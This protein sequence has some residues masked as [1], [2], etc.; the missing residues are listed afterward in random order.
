MKKKKKKK[1]LIPDIKK[2]RGPLS[3]ETRKKI[4]DAFRARRAKKQDAGEVKEQ[5]S[6]ET[7]LSD[8]ELLEK[9]KEIKRLKIFK[10]QKIKEYQTSHGSEYFK[11]FDYQE[12]FLD[13]IVGGKKVVLFQG[14]NQTG[15]TLIAC[16]LM[17]TFG[18]CRQAFEW[19]DKAL[20]KVFGN[21]PVRMRIIA[22][23]WEHHANEVIV[24]KMKE[25]ITAGTYETRKNNVGVEAFWQFKTGSTIEIMTHSQ[26]TKIHEGWTGDIVFADEPMPQDKF[27]ANRRGLIARSG[28]F[29]MTMTAIT[30]PWIMDEIML[31][32]KKHIGCVTN[33]AMRE[34]KFLT[35][36]DVQAF[37]DDC[38][39]E[40]RTARVHGGWL[41]LIGRVLKGYDK[42]IHIIDPFEIPTDW[43]V[44]P[45]I[46]IHL[47]KPQA[48]SF[49][50]VDKQSRRYVIDEIWEHLSPDEI[51]DEIVRRKTKNTW[52]IDTAFIDPL[53][54]GDSA[55]VKNRGLNIEDSFTIIGNK[56]A[57]YGI[58]LIAASKDKKSGIMNLQSW[59]LGVNKMPILFFFRSL[60][61][62]DGAYG[63]LY[64]INRWIYDKEGLPAK[65]NDHFMENLYRYTL[66]GIEYI[67]RKG[68]YYYQQPSTAASHATSWM[69]S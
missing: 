6:A 54:K 33:I 67:E 37:E 25:V 46:D 48:V 62:Y 3:A 19:R 59:L 9:L 68:N 24:P 20:E 12:R 15:K 31:S 26:E 63:H 22:S 7:K 45:F 28:L 35:E 60:P 32:N 40:Q 39:A 11:P 29:V 16:I 23:D 43:P 38:P 27:I 61:S 36:E 30:E 65:L 21:R 51:A 66:A 47:N 34:N 53:A 64:E 4:S 18:N 52:D 5:V 49:Y 69:G 1:L 17:D 14:S 8:E 50:A 10:L 58:Q 13:F 42:D 41:Q 2:R 44:T 56:L 57:N 55:Y